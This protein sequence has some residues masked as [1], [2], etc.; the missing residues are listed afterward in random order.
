MTHSGAVIPTQIYHSG[1]T[2]EEE[3]GSDDIASSYPGQ[4][5]LRLFPIGQFTKVT[6]EYYFSHKKLYTEYA[7]VFR[8]YLDEFRYIGDAGNPY[9]PISKLKNKKN[10]INDN[11]RALSGSGMIAITDIDWKIIAKDYTWKKAYFSDMWISKYGPLPDEFKDTLME[12]FRTKTLL[13]GDENKVY[14]LMKA[15]NKLNSAYGM[16]VTNPCKPDILYDEETGEFKDSERP[17]DQTE[18]EFHQDLL[19]KFY[20]SKNSFLPYQWG[21]WCT[22]WARMQLREMIWKVG[23]YNVYEDTDSIK[24]IDPEHIKPLFDQQ[25]EKIMK[26]A[27]AAGAFALD[28]NGNK[29]YM[30][31]WDYECDKHGTYKRFCTLGAKKYLYEDEQGIHATIAGVNKKYAAKF[32]TEHG[33]EAFKNGTCLPDSGHLVA[34]YNDDLTIKEIE[35]EGCKILNGSNTALI[36]GSY[37]IG[38]TGEWLDLFEKALRNEDLVFTE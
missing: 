31:V 8:V 20:K 7:A 37:T 6:P 3:C 26:E 5:M 15:K 22:A 13:K 16:C 29:K 35:I 32:F 18:L 17:K 21:V 24:Y 11:G 27:E 23:I 28:K 25:N 4:L 34:Y 38:V 33:F 36:N 9:I 2:I 19:D 12:Y 1:V 10:V 30:G 14:E